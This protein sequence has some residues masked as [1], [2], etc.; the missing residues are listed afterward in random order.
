MSETN[1]KN[2]KNPRADLS[3]ALE[4]YQ[5]GLGRGLTADELSKFNAVRRGL[6][7]DE[8]KDSQRKLIDLKIQEREGTLVHR[9]DLRDG[10]N[11]IVSRLRSLADRLQKRFGKDA[12]RMF[13]EA[14][15]GCQEEVDRMFS[16][17][18]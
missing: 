13:D 6:E 9:D 18:S 17:P 10:L 3:N 11:K 1:G 16:E 7:R 2:G 14:L 15:D 4:E 12:A 5:K 8:L